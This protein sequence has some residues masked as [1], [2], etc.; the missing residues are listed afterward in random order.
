VWFGDKKGSPLV[1]YQGAL[2]PQINAPDVRQAL[3]AALTSPSN[4]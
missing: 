3:E 2:T 1:R 4:H